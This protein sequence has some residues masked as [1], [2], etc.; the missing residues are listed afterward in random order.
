M[1]LLPGSEGRREPERAEA[2]RRQRVRFA[3]DVG[4]EAGLAWAH[5]PPRRRSRLTIGAALALAAFAGLG[6][7]PMLLADGDSGLVQPNCDTPAVGAGPSRVGP[8]E[9]FAWQAAGPQ[10]GPY[11]V[12]LDAAEVTGNPAGPV[13]VSTGRVLA[14]PT[15]LPG[16][17]SRQLVAVAPQEKGGHDVVLFRREGDRWVRAALTLLQV[18]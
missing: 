4:D 1:V 14:G 13:R 5:E 18:T 6:A 11:V 16:C 7:L 15:D 17:R 9:N 12:A 3:R 2:A 10:R 8:G